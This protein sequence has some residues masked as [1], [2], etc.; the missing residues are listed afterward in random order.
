MAVGGPEERGAHRP[1]DG[2]TVRKSRAGVAEDGRAVE[3]NAGKVVVEIGV[4]GRDADGL[5]GV[6]GGAEDGGD[7]A[8][9]KTAGVDLLQLEEGLILLRGGG[10]GH[11][12]PVTQIWTRCR[13]LKRIKG[14]STG[15]NSRS[16]FSPMLSNQS[17]RAGFDPFIPE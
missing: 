16:D 5:A 2:G 1:V 8:S 17:E 13:D 6:Q 7:D 12:V 10:H 9:A 11:H 15:L 14:G 3:R 4:G